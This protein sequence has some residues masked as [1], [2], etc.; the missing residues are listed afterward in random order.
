MGYVPRIIPY[1]DEVRHFYMHNVTQLIVAG[2]II[3]NFF[4]NIAE[5]EVDPSGVNSPAVW[6]ALEDLFNAIFLVELIMNW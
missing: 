1:Q 5:K 3:L 4:V 2:M 6:S